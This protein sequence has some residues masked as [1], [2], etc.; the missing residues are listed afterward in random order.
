VRLAGSE[1]RNGP[2]DTRTDVAGRDDAQ[3]ALLTDI[4]W[5]ERTMSGERALPRAG[6]ATA[7]SRDP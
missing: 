5:G 1:A 6:T 2:V 7:P 4:T 3:I